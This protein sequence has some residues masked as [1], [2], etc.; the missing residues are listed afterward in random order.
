MVTH[1]N[2]FGTCLLGCC[3]IQQAGFVILIADDD[4]GKKK[5]AKGGGGNSVAM[6]MGNEESKP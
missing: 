6:G 3:K 5:N 1:F 2:A 4:D